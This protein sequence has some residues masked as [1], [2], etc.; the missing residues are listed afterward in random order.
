MTKCMYTLTFN[1]VIELGGAIS[2]PAPAPSKFSVQ[3]D[4]L[5]K[6]PQDYFIEN[7]IQVLY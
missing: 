1:M 5:V 3:Q 6:T 4:S 7:I 2:F